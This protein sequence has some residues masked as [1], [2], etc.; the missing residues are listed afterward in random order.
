MATP[1]A[2]PQSAAASD[3]GRRSAGGA[4]P[5]SRPM[6]LLRDTPSRTGRPSPRYSPSWLRISRLCASVLPKPMP[7]STISRRALEAGVGP[8]L[9]ARREMVEHVERHVLVRGLQLHGRGLALAVHQHD[10]QAARAGRREAVGVVPQGG[11]VVDHARAGCDRGT[12]HGGLAGIDRDQDARSGERLDHRQSAPDLLVD[13][14]RVRARPR[15]FAADIDDVGAFG[16]QPQP[17]GDRRRRL[18][19]LPAV[20]EAVRGDVDHA[21]EQRAASRQAIRPAGLCGPGVRKA[22]PRPR[23]TSSG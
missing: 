23:A 10:R 15:R 13:R 16:V 12:H 2:A 4:P 17:V 18:E 8:G 7:G 21:H 1:A 20:R 5:A 14:H 11:D 9:H 6:K 3:P 22:A 19:K